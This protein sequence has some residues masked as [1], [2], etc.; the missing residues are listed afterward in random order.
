VDM[1]SKV[2]ISRNLPQAKRRTGDSR[3][4]I[5]SVV[6]ALKALDYLESCGDEAGVTEVGQALGVH[7]STASR[8]LATMESEGY[9]ARNDVTG[10][11]SLGMRIVELA[12]TKLDQ[13]DI[14]TYARPFLEELVQKTQETAHLAIMDQGSIVYIDKV[15]TPHTLIMRSKI[16]YR[17]S[18]HCTALGKAILAALAEARIDAILQ[19]ESLHRFTPNTITDP[20]TFKEH[21]TRVRIQGFAID[22]EEHEEGIRC[23]AAVIRNHTGRVAGAISVSGPAARVSRQRVEEIGILVRDTCRKLSKSLGHNGNHT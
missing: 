8:L 23:A 19:E 4:K 18:P 14:R 16:G 2:D 21:L 13:L 3:S 5:R 11:Y 12:K 6:Q 17:I 7:K 15:D 10:K 9:V 22:D 20:L 1:V